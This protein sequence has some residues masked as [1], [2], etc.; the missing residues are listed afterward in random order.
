MVNKDELRQLANTRW[1]T[2][3]RRSE[4]L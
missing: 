4:I 1:H 3:R 2:S